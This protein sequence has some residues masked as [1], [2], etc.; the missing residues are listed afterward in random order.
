[1]FDKIIQELK[2]IERMKVSIPIKADSDGYYDKECPSQNCLYQFKVDADDWNNKITE[3]SVY[4]PYCGHNAKADSFW[5]TEQISKGK[6]Q[7]MKYY[8]GKLDKIFS[9]GAIDFNR[10]QSMDGFFSIRMEYKGSNTNPIILPIS[11]Q[12][13]LQ[14][15]ITCLKCGSRY[16]VLGSA[17]FCPCC[18]YNSV[19]DTFDNSIKKIEA[20]I[21]NLEL[22]RKAVAEIN[23][24]EAELTVR[25]LI[26]TSLSDAVVAFQRFCELI[27][28]NQPKAEEKIK[29]NAFQNL[30]IGGSYWDNLLGESYNK[31]L[32]TEEYRKL[33]ILFHRR[34]LL[35][36]CEGIV[37]EKYIE[38]SC[39]ESYKVGQ[40][41]VIKQKDVEYLV[42]LIK[43]IVSKIKELT[44]I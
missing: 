1:M 29:L 18:G 5:T 3:D 11:A 33:N 26:E 9:D 4:C 32:N 35:A 34:H 27:Y 6:D 38:K 20:K 21:K 16:A 40:R 30:E 10:H 19:L 24:D 22:I 25:S 39:D 14:Q 42:E 17:F 36:H 43:I 41:I 8:E 12:K 13:E 2:K 37:D 7:A 44:I 28:R 15:K 31:W 23:E